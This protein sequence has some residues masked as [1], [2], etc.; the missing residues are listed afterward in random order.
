MSINYTYGVYPMPTEV[1]RATTLLAATKA[2]AAQIGGTYDDPS[3][4]QMPE[5]SVTVGQAYIN[6][7]SGLDLLRQ[8]YEEA[9]KVLTVYNTVV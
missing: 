8:E 2:L 4:I 1:K 7:K 3:S 6:I 9:K 5:G